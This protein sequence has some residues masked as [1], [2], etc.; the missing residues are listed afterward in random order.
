M[1][2]SVH[3]PRIQQLS[4]DLA[5]GGYH[6]FHAPC[7]ILLDEAER[8]KSTCIRCSWCDGYPCLVHAKA[9]AES[10][11]VRRCSTGRT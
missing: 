6:P 10:I 4:D 1:A 3:E 2:R 8:P 11:A 7:G 5:T 9:D